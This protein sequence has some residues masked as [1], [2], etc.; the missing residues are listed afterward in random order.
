MSHYLRSPLGIAWTARR[1][2]KASLL[3]QQCVFF[4]SFDAA[5]PHG[6]AKALARRGAFPSL[7]PP[8]DA[9]L[10]VPFVPV[11]HPLAPG[12]PATRPPDRRAS[13]PAANDGNVDGKDGQAKRDH[14]ES[15]DREKPEESPQQQR[16]P[17]GDPG[18]PPGGKPLAE[19]VMAPDH[20]A[21]DP[22][23]LGGEDGDGIMYKSCVHSR[24]SAQRGSLP[25]G[26][27]P[28][29]AD[30]RPAPEPDRGA[31]DRSRQHP[32]PTPDSLLRQTL[33]GLILLTWR[34]RKVQHR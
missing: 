16:D 28:A 5:R 14:P 3:P 12:H 11:L 1:R 30:P 33:Q 2:S 13:A 4:Q 17:Q 6:A 32:P 19:M 26:R 8:S 29:R 18:R 23:P 27:N 10:S 7:A 9:A 20:G 34:R 22:C 25:S 21:S 15:Q 31:A 24:T